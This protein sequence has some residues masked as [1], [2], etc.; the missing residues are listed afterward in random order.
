MAE[1]VEVEAR[2]QDVQHLLVDHLLRQT[3]LFYQRANLLGRHHTAAGH[4]DVHTVAHHQVGMVGSPPVG[5]RQ[6]RILPLVP[7][8]LVHQ[9]AV[10]CRPRAVDAIVARHD[11]SHLGFLHGMAEGRQ[12]NLVHR[13][14][15]DIGADGVAVGLRIVGGKVLDTG[16]DAR[17]LLHARD[18]GSRHLCRE[19]RIFAHILEVAGVERRAIDV[20]GWS[21][22]DVDAAGPAVAPQSIAVFMGQLSVPGGGEHHCGGEGRARG[23]SHAH[24]SVGHVY[25]RDAQSFDGSDVET[26][27]V[28]E[29]ELF[30]ERH[31]LQSLPGLHVG[32][33]QLVLPHCRHELCQ[34]EQGQHT[35][36]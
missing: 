25:L 31:L 6:E 23:L 19:V 5:H 9:P 11:R 30:V 8:Q 1:D 27:A 10:L 14:L 3:A 20:D 13:A 18:I 29:R 22:N 4:L 24:R 2:A 26:G 34:Q 12:V 36:F 28:D 16:D 7:E 21:E 17:I 33:G 15:V 35:V 32:L